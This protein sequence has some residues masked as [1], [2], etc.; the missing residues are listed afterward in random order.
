LIR[1]TMKEAGMTSEFVRSWMEDG[2]VEGR[3]EGRE[4]GLEEGREEGRQEGLEALHT[5]ARSLLPA[6]VYA[7]L[8]TIT[9]LN[10]LQAAVQAALLMAGVVRREASHP[11]P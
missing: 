5:L 7:S 11:A 8:A 10:A 2:W 3:Q 1:K 6:E 9:D 4:E